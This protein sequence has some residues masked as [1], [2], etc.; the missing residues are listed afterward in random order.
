MSCNQNQTKNINLI[1]DILIKYGYAIDS[2][3]MGCGKTKSAFEVFKTG[4]YN[5]LIY[6]CPANLIYNIKNESKKW[7]CNINII[8]SYES[9]RSSKNH[10]PKHKLLFRNEEDD[11][12]FTISE[13]FEKILTNNKCLIIT[14]EFHHFVNETYIQKAF[15]CVF[16][17]C[18]LSKKADILFL[19]G[20][21]FDNIYQIINFL[22]LINIIKQNK[23]YIYSTKKNILEFKGF[24]DLID[25]CNTINLTKTKDILSNNLITKKTIFDICY[26]L[27]INI[28]QY[29]I[30]VS[31]DTPNLNIPIYCY[32]KYFSSSSNKIFDEVVK[33]LNI[34]IKNCKDLI[35]IPSLLQQSQIEKI[36]IIVKETSK[37]LD[38]IKNSKVCIYFDFDKPINLCMKLL[39]KYNPKAITGKL[40][41]IE[42]PFE[43]DL[44]QEPNLNSRLLILNSAVG[45]EGFNLDD[46]QGDY[47]RY[48]LACPNHYVKR[49]HQMT[50]RFYRLTTKSSPTIYFVYNKNNKNET[51]ILNNLAKKS[52]ILKETLENQV[53]SGMKFPIDYEIIVEDEIIPQ[54]FDFLNT[55]LN[56]PIKIK[57]INNIESDN[58]VFFNPISK[59]NGF[60]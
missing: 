46:I 7:D 13:K 49:S 48:V 15:K 25:Y 34:E 58:S 42:R 38:N 20:T 2:S 60:F 53:I 51:S 4:G 43:I 26:L 10:Q 23:L 9:F 37:I 18:I 11:D 24:Q 35:N 14:D 57:N 27:Y 1:L 3:P 22:T 6:F 44:F 52:L 50:R 21:P 31:M 17:Y 39:S 8:I 45:S 41:K 30:T 16:N 29:E 19:S 55:K 47:P 32:N 56:N 12:I 33:K 28:I 54:N 59:K 36:E 5:Y 40:N